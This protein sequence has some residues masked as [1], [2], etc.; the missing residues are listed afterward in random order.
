MSEAKKKQ[1]PPAAPEIPQ[2]VD[3]VD[4]IPDRSARRPLW[5]YILIGVLFLAW[6]AFLVYCHLAGRIPGGLAGHP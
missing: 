1:P 2:P 3:V 6:V 5:K 4:G